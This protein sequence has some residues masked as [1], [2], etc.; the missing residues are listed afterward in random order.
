VGNIYN[1]LD[2]AGNTAVIRTVGINIAGGGTAPIVFTV[3]NNTIRDIRSTFYNTPTNMLT[4][5]GSS[6]VGIL[7]T[8]A[9]GVKSTIEG[10]TIYNIRN[11]QT[12]G[13]TG[14]ASGITIRG[15]YN[16]VQRNRIYALSTD[17]VSTTQD[18]PALLG[19]YVQ[20]TASLG[21]TVRNNQ[22]SLSSSAGNVFLGG[23]VDATNFGSSNDIINNSIFIGGTN[24]GTSNSYGI[25]TGVFA[26]P[27]T[28]NMYNNIVYNSRTGGNGSHFAAGSLYNTTSISAASFGYNLMV[29]GLTGS[30]LEMPLG[31]SLSSSAVNAMYTSQSSNSNWMETTS[32]LP[33]TALF[34]NTAI[35]N[36][37]LNAA[38]A[39]SWYANGKG[40]PM[41]T[42]TNDFN[43]ITRSTNITSGA[44]DIGAVEVTPTA[45]PASATA[46][47]V[48]ALNTTTTYTYGGRTVASVTWGAT[49]TV[50]TALDV[51]YYSGTNAPS[52]LASKTQYNAYYAVTP[53]GGTGYT[54]SIALSYDSAVMGNVGSTQASRLAYY[55][56]SNAT[57]NLL[58]SSS[59]NSV[60]GMLV[61]GSSLAATSL[62]AN[63]TGTNISNPLPVRLVKFAGLAVS[64]DVQL[65]WVTVSEQNN[66]GFI[67]ERS[68]DAETFEEVG[69][70]KGSGNSNRMVNYS[71]TDY[72]AFDMMNSRSI[73]YRLKQLD[74]DGNSSYS[75]VI[76][77]TDEQKDAG[78]S[79]YPN[80]T[81][82]QFAVTAV[83]ASDGVM[84]ITILDIQG[85][86]VANHSKE[87]SAGMNTITMDGSTLGGTG[88][89]FVK[90]IVGGETKVMKLMKQ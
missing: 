22:I 16:I 52:L 77:V 40:L 42:V 10:N 50:P 55:R 76:N 5:S 86:V 11:N 75:D 74:M 26:S 84:K 19:V 45:A 65:G 38:N 80:P 4:Y 3:T 47:A 79:L 29:T 58:S 17:A 31:T 72:N 12:S 66:K 30:L 61:S 46:S 6:P 63:F 37:G 14:Q 25:V 8:A 83:A 89:Y 49:G 27:T 1:Y 9:V 69:F 82:D 62:P 34:A 59:A 41:A 64:G 81:A 7:V 21:Q 43:N 24:N 20:S 67:V 78:M 68:A 15:G 39:A 53:T 56:T 57:W 35:G 18:A 88:V 32:N 2:N 28:T 13:V 85:K 71:L 36:L 44:T 23:V 48:P 51:K 60:S 90:V 70:V 73:Y 33:S 54:Y 87:V